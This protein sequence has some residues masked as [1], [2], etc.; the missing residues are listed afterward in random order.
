MLITAIKTIWPENKG[1]SIDRK[2]IGDMYVFV[3]FLS[4]VVLIQ[5]EDRI[6]VRPGGCILFDKYSHQ[7]FIC[8]DFPLTH[9]WFH[10]TGNISNLLQKYHIQPQKVYYPEQDEHITQIIQNMEIEYM[11]QKPYWQ[12]ICALSFEEIL[13]CLTREI[14]GTEPVKT[15]K[16]E[17]LI[18]LRT[19][20]HLEYN[21]NWTVGKM[22]KLVGMS[23]SRF[24]ADYGN[25]FG[26]SP[27]KDLQNT[28]I[29]HA[30][31][32]LRSGAD[33]ASVAEQT[34]FSS[35]YHFIRAFKTKCGITPG[36]YYKSHR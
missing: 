1:F 27:S 4:P 17:A 23:E 20:V 9:N 6:P 8:P 30:K 18:K 14:S 24:Y 3:H 2:N 33:V 21:Q 5:N 19:Q 15:Q 28:R 32:L 36:K 22:A 26:I 10:M 25:V 11:S 16:K 34:G 31:R 7:H 13:A 35:T 12:N 29:E